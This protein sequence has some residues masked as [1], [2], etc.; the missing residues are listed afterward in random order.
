MTTPAAT[1]RSRANDRQASKDRLLD[2]AV[3]EFAEYGIAGARVD[4]IAA[5]ARVNKSQLYAYFGNKQQLFDSVFDLHLGDIASRVPMDGRD[6]P[7]YVVRLYDFYLDRPSVVRLATWVRLERVTAGWLGDAALAAVMIASIDDAQRDGCVTTRFTAEEIYQLAIGISLTWSP[8]SVTTAATR[9][10][11]LE[12]HAR[13]RKV[14]H[15]TARA[16][17]AP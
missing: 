8:A 7:G 16:A 14:L 1:T 10:D 3:A 11:A 4:R 15:D 9:S 17:F 2:A 12:L 6:L 13:R 5:A